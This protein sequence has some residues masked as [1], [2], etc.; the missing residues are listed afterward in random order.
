MGVSSPRHPQSEPSDTVPLVPRFQGSAARTQFCSPAPTSSLRQQARESFPRVDNPGQR[1]RSPSAGHPDQQSCN[2]D[3]N[4]GSPD[5]R[6]RAFDHF[7]RHPEQPWRASNRCNV[8]G[9]RQQSPG[10][11]VASPKQQRRFPGISM[12]HSD[13]CRMDPDIMRVRRQDVP[14]CRNVMIMT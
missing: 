5:R 7:T 10:Y 13:R 3:T 1:Q 12:H 4:V 14:E 8:P 9:R 2:P 11:N 6:S